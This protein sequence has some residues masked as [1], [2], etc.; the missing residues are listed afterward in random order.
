MSDIKLAH[1]INPIGLKESDAFSPIQEITFQ[2]IVNAKKYSGV[3][4]ITL[5]TTQFEEDR[6]VIPADFKILANLNRS[7]QDEIQDK[8]IRKLPF[9]DDIIK[10]GLQNSDADYL[11][12]TNM[13]IGLMPFFYDFVLQQITEY[14]FDAMLITRR[15]IGLQYKSKT[16][17]TEIYADKGKP[18][19]GYDAFVM[20]R[21]VAEKLILDRICVGVPFI[22]VSL[23]HNLIA[24]SQK[25]KVFDQEHLTFHIGM[26]VMPPVNSKLYSYNR[27]VYE[28][29]IFPKIKLLLSQEKFPYS[30]EPFFKRLVIW[31][32]NPCYRTALMLEMERMSFS[33]KLKFLLDELRW[34]ILQG[35]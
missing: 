12:F 16:Q 9:V 30:D 26:E 7:V 14:G 2:S 6:F 33:R 20:H 17:M 21:T 8:S 3:Q 23:L 25:L 27:H 4:S 34:K 11:I 28:K 18:H 35:S 29:N 32:L 13:D 1:I 19:P 24:F 15:R 31:G 10:A 5:L 22:E